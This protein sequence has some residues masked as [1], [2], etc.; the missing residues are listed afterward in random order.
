MSPELQHTP[1]QASS[2]A[3]LRHRSTSSCKHK[4][5]QQSSRTAN[6]TEAHSQVL[7]S[8]NRCR[9]HSQGFQRRRPPCGMRKAMAI[10]HVAQPA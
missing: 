10:Q 8:W 4:L 1:P 7:L 3:G 6:G 2:P 9:T 5:C